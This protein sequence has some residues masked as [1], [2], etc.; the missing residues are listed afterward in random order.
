MLAGPDTGRPAGLRR[1]TSSV[2]GVAQLESWCEG[3][4]EAGTG[5]AHAEEGR[6]DEGEVGPRQL[7]RQ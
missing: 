2:P 4:R 5:E 6:G 7:G 3:V 1:R